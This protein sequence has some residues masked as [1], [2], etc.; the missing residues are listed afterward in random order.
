MASRTWAIAFCRRW[1]ISC[2]WRS[3]ALRRSEARSYRRA[4]WCATRPHSACQATC[5]WRAGYPRTAHACSKRWLTC[6]AAARCLLLLR[7]H[8]RTRAGSDGAGHRVIG[9]QEHTCRRVV[10]HAVTPGLPCRALQGAEHVQQRGR[11]QRRWRNWPSTVRAGHRCERRGD[12]RHESNPIETAGWSQWNRF[13]GDA[14]L[15]APGP[16]LLESRTGVPVV[17]VVP[18][19]DDLRLPD[20]DAASFG[21]PSGADGCVEI[22]V[23]RLPHIANFDEFGAIAAETGVSLRY[24]THAEELRA[25]DLVIVP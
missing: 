7:I 10:S 20:E 5:A 21:Q 19:L 15:L 13:R 24:V 1:R 18:Y 4:W 2:W 23:V 9:W 6:T 12:G 14:A 25:P 22:A 8:E 17:G 11:L 16:A 3:A